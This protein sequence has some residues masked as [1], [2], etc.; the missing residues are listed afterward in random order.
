MKIFTTT[1]IWRPAS[2]VRKE[3]RMYFFRSRETTLSDHAS[4]T[5]YTPSPIVPNIMIISVT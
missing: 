5:L 2:H 3:I 4:N 1:S